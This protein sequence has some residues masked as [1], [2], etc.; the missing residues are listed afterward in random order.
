MEMVV[1][2]LRA[3]VTGASGAIG[4]PLVDELL[5]C[6][7]HVRALA[8]RKSIEQSGV[9]VV[10][11]S[12]FAPDPVWFTDIDVVFHLAAVIQPPKRKNEMQRINVEAVSALTEALSHHGGNI[13]LLFTS[14]TAALGPSLDGQ[15]LI[16]DTPPQPITEY[17]HTKMQAERIVGGYPNHYIIR[18]PMVVGPHDRN[19]TRWEKLVRLGLFPVVPYRF[20]LVHETDVIRCLLHLAA[21]EQPRCIFTISDG[22][23]YYWRDIAQGMARLMNKRVA[24]LTLPKFLFQPAL[25]GVLGNA[26][27]P[28]YLLNDWHCFP[29]LPDDFATKTI[30]FPPQATSH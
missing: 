27:L 20:S 6:G 17:G 10:H 14:T 28:A 29:D 25:L 26:D 22:H 7:A 19:T 15:P 18:L 4:R 24:C 23:V 5:N 9:E 1:K 8:H 21:S 30:V 2:Q 16:T 13:R 11:G 3:F 12:I